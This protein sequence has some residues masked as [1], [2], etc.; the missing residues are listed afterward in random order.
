MSQSSDPTAPKSIQALFQSVTQV[1]R[2]IQE[3]WN[4]QDFDEDVTID[5]YESPDAVSI[6]LSV[7]DVEKGREV[8]V[9]RIECLLSERDRTICVDS[10]RSNAIW[11]LAQASDCLRHVW[12][13]GVL[14][15]KP[16]AAV[17]TQVRFNAAKINLRLF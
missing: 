5:Y 10:D 2:D 4:L 3:A 6:Q 7:I 16:D 15:L 9:A 13:M 14:D 8:E 12:S 1:M 17:A 11:T